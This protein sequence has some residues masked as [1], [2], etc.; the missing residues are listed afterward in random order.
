[1]TATLEIRCGPPDVSGRR[2]ITATLGKRRHRDKF[3]ID[4]SFKRSKFRDKVIGVFGLD[5]TAHEFI[6][7]QISAAAEA[8]GDDL[9]AV[10]NVICMADVEAK[11][12]K[13]HW[14]QYIPACAI[15]LFSSDPGTGKS[16]ALTD[17]MAR[18][19]RGDSPPPHKAPDGTFPRCNSLLIQG[20]DDPERTVKPRL[21]AAGGDE[22]RVHLLRTVTL[23]DEERGVQLPLDL[24]IIEKF[25]REHGINLV[26]ID[27]LSA[28]TA[29]GVSLN[30]DAH[31]RRL[32]NPIA[33]VAER[34][35][36]TWILLS[37]LNKK[38]NTP[39]L[40]RTGGSIALIGAARAA[41]TFGPHPDDPTKN[42]FAPLKHNLGPR[43][44]SLTY[45]IEPYGDTSRI[46]WGG[47][48]HLTAGDVLA[49]HSEKS[50]ESKTE[51][52]KGIIVQML[53]RGP[54]G[55]SEVF[56]ACKQAG[57]SETTYRRAR[58]DL[59]VLSD[60]A[61]FQGKWQLSLPRTN[62]VWHDDF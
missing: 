6:E 2:T 36:S 60:K 32:T 18:N 33:A 42:V 34:T 52:A 56:T 55:E 30:D 38:A 26:G 47:Q 13:W 25:I 5:E 62:G 40:Y 39:T 58:S 8:Q 19:S 44:H 41:F 12:T 7:D 27:T 43:P 10:A 49:T 50:G 4:D 24:P 48:T 20:E 9:L 23:C 16:T 54:R 31:V 51:M 57:I 53:C 35:Q 22:S 45:T 46:V 29:P 37:H 21:L 28:F 59:G 14:E 15:T 11:K 17:L 61:G 1:M 3:D